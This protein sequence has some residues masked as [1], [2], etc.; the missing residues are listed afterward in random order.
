MPIKVLIVDDQSLMR[1]GLELLLDLSGDICV[2]GL[3]ENGKD[4]LEKIALLAPDV[5]LLDIR[6]PVMN[7]VE[8]TK[9]IK[10]NYPQVKVLILT[11]FD[12]DEYIFDCL[13][14]GAQG[15]LLKDLSSDKLLNA[16][17]DAYFSKAVLQPEVAAKVIS[18]ISNDNSPFASTPK[19]TCQTGNYNEFSDREKSILRYM[20][21]GLNNREISKA[22]FITEGTVKNYITGIYT[23]LGMNDRT[24]AVIYAV[25]NKII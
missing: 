4:A 2:A 18:R 24:K 5:V 14:N 8:C 16:I 17:K 25:E 13:K 10:E 7:G 9:K 19:N 11:T 15:Y 22:L 3:A 21:K 20:A 1:E 23:K 6:M 12:D